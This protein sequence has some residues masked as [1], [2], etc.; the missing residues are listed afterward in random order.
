M[1]G[2]SPTSISYVYEGRWDHSGIYHDAGG[3]GAP[4][5][6]A[7]LDTESGILTC[8]THITRTDNIH[9]KTDNQTMDGC[10]NGEWTS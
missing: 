4:K 1:S 9:S 10:Y 3:G 6:Y 8:I 5:D 2:A 7:H